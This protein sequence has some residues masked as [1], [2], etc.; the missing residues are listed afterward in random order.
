LGNYVFAALVHTVSLF[1]YQQTGV[2]EY[3]VLSATLMVLSTLVFI[4]GAASLVS[5]ELTI[6]IG[7]EEYERQS[8]YFGRGVLQVVVL[9]IAYHAY[10]AGYGLIAGII[11]FQAVILLVSSA[12]SLWVKSITEED[13]VGDD[14]E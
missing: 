14:E 5:P 6:E 7:E 4:V 9:L 12:I 11:G 2:I 10:S 8:D 13:E 1:I 3:M